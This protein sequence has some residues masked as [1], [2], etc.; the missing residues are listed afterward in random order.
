MTQHLTRLTHTFRRPITGIH[1]P[2]RGP[3]LDILAMLLS[4]LFPSSTTLPLT[5]HLRTVL[6][7]PNTRKVIIIAHGTGAIALSAALDS[8]HADLPMATMSKLEVYTFG[9]AAR[10]LNNPLLALDELSRRD[11]AFSISGGV[12]HGNAE[13]V[14][15]RSPN[16]QGVFTRQDGSIASPV[17]ATL[18]SLGHRVE[19]LERVMLHVEHYA[20]VGD[21]VARCGVVE[22]VM[23]GA[24]RFVGRL[25]LIGEVR[26]SGIGRE[27]PMRRGSGM[28]AMMEK[29]R[30]GSDTAVVA[31]TGV[32]GGCGTFGEYM[33]ALFPRADEATAGT[34][35]CLDV[36]VSVDA[37]TAERREFS[38][39]G[40]S[41]PLK[42][43]HR[44]GMAI[45]AHSQ[46]SSQS[47]ETSPRS[48][49]EKLSSW[50]TT[51]ALGVDSVG[52][53]RMGA[54]ECQG[55][56]VRQLSRLW[57]F[58]GGEKPVGEGVCVAN[59]V[60]LAGLGKV[61]MQNGEGEN[62]ER[63]GGVI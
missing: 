34:E 4:P 23:G 52:K 43:L 2:T 11:V 36:V 38:A 3:L 58:G 55:R 39:E 20:M 13:R 35:F 10:H 31:K 25:F 30:R 16:P 42:S 61:G 28:S 40:I 41:S 63:P 60:G 62:N 26:G 53:A 45:G 6:I 47:L 5:T 37:R 56:T 22:A 33:D 12:T 18:A 49:K 15:S 59:G 44:M 21:L 14:R 24:S 1:N 8:L 17:K 54:R 27:M 9:S 46:L 50:G 19:D 48:R 57:K 32:R 51:G 7:S 29:M